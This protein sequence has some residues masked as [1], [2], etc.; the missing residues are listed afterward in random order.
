[1]RYSVCALVL[2]CSFG[3][4]FNFSL[5]TVAFSRI[6][7][8]SAWHNCNSLPCYRRHLLRM[9]A[10]YLLWSARFQ[11]IFT[12]QDKTFQLT[13]Q[14]IMVNNFPDFLPCV[15]DNGPQHI[16]LNCSVFALIFNED[17]VQN[18]IISPFLHPV[19]TTDL[20]KNNNRYPQ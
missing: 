4:F 6:P 8:Y 1:M 7:Q 5:L 11:L 10:L 13:G 18:F 12:R 2:F 16:Y 9:L 3:Q 14:H 20:E 19:Q 17:G 15:S